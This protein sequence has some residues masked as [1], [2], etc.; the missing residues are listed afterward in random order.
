M[1]ILSRFSRGIIAFLQYFIFVINGIYTN[2]QNFV[3]G[4]L[5]DY[6]VSGL[7]CPLLDY[8][9]CV[10]IPLVVQNIFYFL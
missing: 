1:A 2:P 5:M 4:S 3:I 7:L 6:L 8:I 10:S 9:L